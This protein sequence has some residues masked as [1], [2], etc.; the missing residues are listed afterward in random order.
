MQLHDFY[1]SLLFWDQEFR[2]VQ[3]LTGMPY[4]LAAALR[5]RDSLLAYRLSYTIYNRGFP[6]EREV[7]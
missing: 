1:D 6:T 2:K 7:G 5:K 3:L 4:P